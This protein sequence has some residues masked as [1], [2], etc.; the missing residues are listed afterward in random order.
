MTRERVREN[1]WFLR[2][3]IASAFLPY[4]TIWVGWWTREVGRQPWVV[5][6]LMR[7]AQG[8]SRMSVAQ[9]V[10]WL[11]GYV[12]FELMVWGATWWFLGKLIHQGPDMSAPI[13]ADGRESLGDM[14]KEHEGATGH[15][16]SPKAS[17]PAKPG[18]LHP[19]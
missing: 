15:V 7:T 4:I 2:A 19:A 8:V 16:E 14:P 11:V 17:R 10:F 18:R 1:K 3:T 9:E 5:Y 13:P 12:G 6:G